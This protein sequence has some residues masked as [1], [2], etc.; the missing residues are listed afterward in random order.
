[1][2]YERGRMMCCEKIILWAIFSS[3]H[4]SDILG[5]N[6]CVILSNSGKS[7]CT[8]FQKMLKSSID[9]SEHINSIRL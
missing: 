2:R 8:L 1:M 6:N 7:V 3:F 4:N 5:Q 9:M